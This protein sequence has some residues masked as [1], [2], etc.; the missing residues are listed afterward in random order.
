MEYYASVIKD[1]TFLFVITCLESDDF[2]LSEIKQRE[3]KE[4]KN[5]FPSS[6]VYREQCKRIGL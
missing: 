3:K 1:K 6:V 4:L 5:N 2:V